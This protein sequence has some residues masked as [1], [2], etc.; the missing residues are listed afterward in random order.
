MRTLPSFTDGDRAGNEPVVVVSES[1]AQR[2][3]PNHDALNRQLWWTETGPPF[4]R[5]QPCRIVGVVADVDDENVIPGPA[6]TVYHPMRQ[7][8]VPGRLFVHA[9]G[10]PYAL[11]PEVT[12]VIRAISADQ[13]VERAA[14]LEDI[15]AEVLAPER[16]NAFVISGFSGVALLIAAVG[17]AGVLTFSA[18]ARTREFGVRLA[19]GATRRDLVMRVLRDGTLIVTIGIAAGA[20]GGYAFAGVATSM[21]DNMD[22]PGALP[23]LAAAA[24]LLGV[25]ILASLMPAA[26]ASHVDVMEALRSE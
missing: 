6:L 11:V 8:G 1:I 10:D 25:G 13:P 14:T 2:L 7:A 17:V 12:R 5:A 9:S 18:S 16:L 4:C 21:V 26:R 20:A 15:R 3:F 24:V 23:L 19:M 22:L